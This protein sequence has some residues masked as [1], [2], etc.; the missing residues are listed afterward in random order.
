MDTKFGHET[1][2]T[3]CVQRFGAPDSVTK[4]ITAW[5][6]RDGSHVALDTRG[7]NGVAKFWIPWSLG[8]DVAPPNGEVY[9]PNRGRNSNTYKFTSLA[10]DKSVAL[11]TLS[12]L[13]QVE[14]FV[15]DRLKLTSAAAPPEGHQ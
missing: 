9:E 1:A 11:L 5:R 7:G 6:M 8:I 15:A 4:Y 10:P 2:R 12:T 14:A 13:E 3:L